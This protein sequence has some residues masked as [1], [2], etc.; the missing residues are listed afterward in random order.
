MFSFLYRV[1]YDRTLFS[2]YVKNGKGYGIKLL[3]ILTL[4]IAFCLSAHLFWVFTLVSSRFV[5][6]FVAQLPEIVVR[7]GVIVSPD[8]YHYSYISEN[9]QIFFV[10]DTTGQPVNLKNLPSTGIYVT[11]DALL[12]VR[13]NEWRRLPFVKILNKTDITLNR[14]NLRMAINE[15]RTMSKLVAPP[16]VFVLCMPGIFGAYL[17]MS[18]FFLGISFIITQALKIRLDW[19]ER[20]RLTALSLMPAGVING[21]GILLDVGARVERLGIVIIIVYM[22]CFLK[23]GAAFFENKNADR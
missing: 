8:N 2:F 21:M 13:R 12:T 16:V 4:F 20:A 7:N 22:Y 9:R 10:F 23:D 19:K 1:F 15:A 5:N 11:A 14:E 18:L 17:F 3:F 6:E